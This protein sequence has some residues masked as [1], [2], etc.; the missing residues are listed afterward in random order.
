MLRGRGGKIELNLGSGL[1]PIAEADR[2]SLS[3]GREALPTTTQADESKTYIKGL[4]GHEGT[5]N[6][7]IRLYSATD[8]LSAAQII[9]LILDNQGSGINVSARLYVQTPASAMATCNVTTS[10]VQAA[11]FT[12]DLLFT[13]TSIDMP[14]EDIITCRSSFTVTGAVTWNNGAT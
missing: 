6:Y 1:K 13:N 3:L 9:P 8:R 12:G 7:F 4:K 2:W 5:V 11:Y 14:A 10:Y